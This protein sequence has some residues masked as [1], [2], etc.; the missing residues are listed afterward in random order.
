MKDSSTFMTAHDEAVARV[1]ADGE[2]RDL[3]RRAADEE[4]GRVTD[5]AVEQ[6]GQL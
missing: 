3:A 5:A 6:R 4:D 2:G 1:E